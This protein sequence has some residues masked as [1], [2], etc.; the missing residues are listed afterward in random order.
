MDRTENMCGEVYIEED[1]PQTCRSR[2][3]S[4]VSFDPVRGGAARRMQVKLKQGAIPSEQCPERLAKM[5]QI[6]HLTSVAEATH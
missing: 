3:K 1:V 4:D 2:P 6:L 5:P